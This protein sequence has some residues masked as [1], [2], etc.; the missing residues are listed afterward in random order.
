M[1]FTKPILIVFTLFVYLL[2]NKGYSQ[3]IWLNDTSDFFAFEFVKPTFDGGNEG[4]KFFSAAY[5]FSFGKKL[6]NN[7]ML[8]TELPIAYF[9]GDFGDSEFAVG[10][11]YAGIRTS[12]GSP[13]SSGEFGVYFPT[14]P[15]DKPIASL[16]AIFSDPNRIESFAPETFGLTAKVKFEDD[17]NDNGLYYKLRGGFLF[18]TNTDNDFT[19]YFLDIS[20][21][22]GYL[23]DKVNILTGISARIGLNEDTELDASGDKTSMF[24]GIA[25]SYRSDN[26]EPG[27]SLR[28][29][30][31]NPYKDVIS[32][33]FG[34]SLLFHLN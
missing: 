20:G 7:T 3:N 19:G 21:Q 8:I 33:S 1:K 6:G 17:I 11:I 13:K 30:I 23:S 14:A 34:I 10:N 9:H 16:M 22:F 26:F 12:L 28:I 27:L 5:V 2:S 32:N 24:F 4:I 31:D 25:L 18:L 29:P 15:D